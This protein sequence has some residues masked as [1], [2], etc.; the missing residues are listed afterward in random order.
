MNTAYLLL[1]SNMGNKCRM[2]QEAS[3]LVDRLAGKIFQYSSL[4]ESEPW[5]FESEEWFI[6]QAI[7]IYTS[8][9]PE[10]LLQTT[11]AIERTLGRNRQ[12]AVGSQQYAARPIDIDIL[13]YNE[14]IIHTPALTIPHPLLH[15]RLFGLRPLAEI[16][17]ALVHP[18]LKKT[19]AT[20]LEECSDKGIVRKL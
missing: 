11:Q 8:L 1:G 12:P 20:L 17:A 15:E 18:E 2:L 6:N 16:A 5:G 13:F 3:A 19:I 14:T 7:A 4:Y 10:R 9:S